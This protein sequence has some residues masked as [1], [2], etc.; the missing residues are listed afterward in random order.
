MTDFIESFDEYQ[1]LAGETLGPDSNPLMLA[2]GVGGEAGEVLEVIKKGN[3]PGKVVDT[4]HLEEELGDLLWYIANLADYY[5]IDLI[6]VATNN[7][8]KLRVRY[9]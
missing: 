8:E 5:G 3:R 1:D 4:V 2:L 6:D 7:I 9:G